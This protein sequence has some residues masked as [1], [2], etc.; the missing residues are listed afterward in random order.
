[1][2]TRRNHSSK[3]SD[4]NAAAAEDMLKAMFKQAK[5]QFGE[6]AKAFWFYDGDLCPAC[7]Q[8]P[9]GVVKFKG[10]DALAING[11]MYRERGILIGYFLCEMCA[12]YIHDHAQKHPYQQTSLHTKIESN[13]IDAY[14]KHLSSFN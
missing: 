2:R 11:F 7:L 13:L 10:E 8:N 12:L 6:A 4:T 14:H 3:P 1:M 9:I 5:L